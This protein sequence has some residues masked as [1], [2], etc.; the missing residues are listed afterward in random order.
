VLLK[1]RQIHALLD[2]GQSSIESVTSAS[3]NA[4]AINLEAK[5]LMKADPLLNNTK[6]YILPQAQ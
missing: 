3:L 1:L 2:R 5:S 6:M 4:G